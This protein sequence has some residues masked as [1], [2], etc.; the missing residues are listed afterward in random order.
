MNYQKIIYIQFIINQKKIEED[1]TEKN[2]FISAANQ[3]DVENSENSDN[4]DFFDNG[5]LIKKKKKNEDIINLDENNDNNNEEDNNNK[6]INETPEQ[7]EEKIAGMTLTEALKKSKIKPENVNMSLL[8]QI[9]G[10]DKNFQKMK[11]F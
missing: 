6:E 11:D 8:Q 7:A 9:W 2:A 5:L 10:D 3:E 1:Q 4:E